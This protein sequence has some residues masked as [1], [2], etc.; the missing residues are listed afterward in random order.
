MAY[1]GCVK[2]LFAELALLT[3]KRVANKELYIFKTNDYGD[4]KGIDYLITNGKR[5]ISVAVTNETITDNGCTIC[6]LFENRPEVEGS[7]LKV[8]KDFDWFDG[9]INKVI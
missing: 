9:E 5:F 3:N 8:T 4:S 2:E 7:W 6:Y 1:S